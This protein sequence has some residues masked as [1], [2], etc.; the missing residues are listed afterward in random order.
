MGLYYFFFFALIKKVNIKNN[1]RITILNYTSLQKFK[2]PKE[3]YKSTVK[4]LFLKIYYLS[5]KASLALLKGLI[6]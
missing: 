4:F 1:N 5:L 2:K 3:L 6:K